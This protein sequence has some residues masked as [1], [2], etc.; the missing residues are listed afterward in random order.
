MDEVTTGARLGRSV[1]RLGSLQKERSWDAS[2]QEAGPKRNGPTGKEGWAK[3]RRFATQI[4][5]IMV[6]DEKN[7]RRVIFK[8]SERNEPLAEISA[9]LLPKKGAPD[10]AQVHICE[11]KLGVS[12]RERSTMSGKSPFLFASSNNPGQ[13]IPEPIK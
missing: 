1:S 13:G 8:K 2:F 10:T 3:S 12:T 11:R 7:L 4:E 6:V 5:H 9:S